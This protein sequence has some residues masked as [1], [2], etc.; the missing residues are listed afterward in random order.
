MK[1]AFLACGIG[2]LVLSA[3]LLV[4]GLIQFILPPEF[5]STAR[6]SLPPTTNEVQN[7][8]LAVEVERLQS[9]SILYPVITNLDLNSRWG[10]KFKEGKLA[11]DL[12]Y[13]LLRNQLR[14][15]SGRGTSL[16]EVHVRSDDSTEAAAIANKIAEVYLNQRTTRTV[17]RNNDSPLMIRDPAVELIDAAEPDLLPVKPSRLMK[18]LLPA[19]GLLAAFLGVVL[20]VFGVAMKRSSKRTPPPLPT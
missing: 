9:K 11:A 8:A 19:G 13:K 5:E 2:L 3:V 18:F 17:N 20:L 12:T 7:V 15:K 16:I 10:E 1:K 6:L 4:G 14:I